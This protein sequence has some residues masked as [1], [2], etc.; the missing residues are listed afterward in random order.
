MTQQE[1]YAINLRLKPEDKKSI[2]LRKKGK[3]IIS[4]LRSGIAVELKKSRED[5]DEHLQR[6]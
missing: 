4:I 6:T 5:K 1:S 2:D 3:T